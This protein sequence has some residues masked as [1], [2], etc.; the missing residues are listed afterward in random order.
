[1]AKRLETR[2]KAL[3]RRSTEVTLNVCFAKVGETQ[4]QSIARTWPNGLPLGARVMCI[5]WMEEKA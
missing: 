1:M 3:E 5:R 4:A 2:L